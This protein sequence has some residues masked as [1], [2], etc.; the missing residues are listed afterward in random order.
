MPTCVINSRRFRFTVLLTSILLLTS[1]LNP[2][3]V[4]RQ[5]QAERNEPR[6]EGKR[7]KDEEKERQ[8]DD[9]SEEDELNRGLWEFARG[10]PY[11]QILPYVAEAQRKSRANEVA[12]VELPNGWRLAPAGRQID[13]GRLPYEAVPFAGKLV[14]LN[15]GHYY[16]EPQE[17]S[18]VDTDSGTV[19]KTLK[20]NSLFPS[21]VVGPDADLY[22][23]G[24]FD[25]KVFRIDKQFS[26]LREYP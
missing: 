17:V 3:Q 25:Q 22:I 7:D 16:K 23:S 5:R 12:E 11:D 1:S 21:A 24:G 26:I 9:P 8:V 19:E 4:K 10:T 2:A 15:T 20:I 6:R 14:V 18:V 13:V